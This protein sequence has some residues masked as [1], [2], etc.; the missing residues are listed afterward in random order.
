MKNL[1]LMSVLLIFKS[2]SAYAI[3]DVQLDV[4]DQNFNSSNKIVISEDE[5]K[6]SHATSL[7]QLLSSKTNINIFGS[8]FQPNTIYLRGGDSRHILILVDGIPTYDPG[9]IQ[10]TANL[11]NINLKN[12]R[13]IEIIKG[14]QSVIYGGQ[15]LAGVIKIET[16][17]QIE[18]LKST[19]TVSGGKG[20]FDGATSVIIPLSE[21]TGLELAV[22][23]VDENNLSPV[24][25]SAILYPRKLMTVNG[26]FVYRD[27]FES[28]F[29][30]NYS[31]EKNQITDSVSQADFSALDALGNNY[32]SNS[33]LLSYLIRNKD[34]KF[35]ISELKSQRDIFRLAVDNP[36]PPPYD[37]E[38]DQNYIGKTD[39]VHFDYSGLSTESLK[40]F[41]GLDFSNDFLVYKNAG[42]ISNEEN[43][44]YESAY[45][46][47]N[48]LLNAFKFEAGYR[49][50]FTKL[51][52][53]ND[54]FQFGIGYNDEIKLE[55]STGYNQPSLTQLYVYNANPKLQPETAQTATLSYDKK[56]NDQFFYS[57]TLFESKF[58][59]LIFRTGSPSKNENIASAVTQGIE[60]E[61]SLQSADAGFMVSLGYTYQEPKDLRRNSWL[62]RRPLHIANLNMKLNVT[63]DL[64]F[65]LD[66][67]RTGERVDQSGSTTYVTVAAN[68]VADVSATY[69]LNKNVSLF[70][71]V[72]NITNSRHELAYGYFT[73][74]ISAIAGADFTF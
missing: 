61:T 36:N 50:Q 41:L 38:L 24:K 31:D 68:T 1:L 58:E 34:F 13:K 44:Q 4:V 56:F 25:D 42:I 5:I 29:K 11:A 67:K 53:I 65:K 52:S 7:T 18:Q 66:I 3:Q 59:N 27:T 10:K 28:I 35:S 15:A 21:N 2:T 54:S 30:V 63:D 33:L 73:E 48:Y 49:K 74:G 22:S 72:N 17:P 55:F 8:G 70:T 45:L 9:T 20:K 51:V 64:N 43:Q 12:I 62:V 60:L 47:T 26:A 37:G 39:Q 46:K 40:L 71:R 14:S 6:Q 23:H 69:N 57:A 19:S 32:N 16:I